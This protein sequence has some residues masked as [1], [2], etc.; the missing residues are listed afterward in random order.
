MNSHFVDFES[1]Q[2]SL[3][4]TNMTL[5]VGYLKE[6]YKDLAERGDKKKGISKITFYDYIK[7]PILIADK[8]FNAL[9]IDNDSYLNSK[10]F[11]E[12][13]QD[14]YMGDFEITL[15]IIFAILDFDKDSKIERDDVR[16]ILSHLPLKT[17]STTLH[18]KYQL[19]SLNEIEDILKCMFEPDEDTLTLD[20][21]KLIIENN[22]S[23]VYLQL[24]CFLYMKKP[25]NSQ[26]I[27][28]LGKST[29]SVNFCSPLNT[30]SSPNLI[31]G[32]KSS[33]KKLLTPNRK[34]TFSP[35]E[36]FIKAS[37]TQS[38]FSL[39][40]SIKSKKSFVD[41]NTPQMSGMKGMVRL[42]N[43]IIPQSKAITNNNNKI[44]NV[45][46][47]A[48]K[49]YVS[50][51]DF[52][53]QHKKPDISN[54]KL[55]NKIIHLGKLDFDI[56]SDS[57]SDVEEDE[58]DNDSQQKAEQD[59]I[60]EISYE[61]W[62][63]KINESNKIIKYFLVIICKDIYYYKNN[64]K[65]ELLGMH[66]LSGCYVKENG[67]KVINQ[68]KYYC[69]Q[70]IFPSKQR[71]YYT[72]TLE[73]A[74]TFVNKIKQQLNYLNF[75]EYYEMIDDLGEG[76]FGQVKLGIHKTTK[77]RVAI[78][79]I[80]RQQMDESDNELVRSEIDIMKLCHHP[81]IVRLLDHFENAEYIFI[82][83]EYIQGGC[84]ESYLVNNKFALSEKRIAKLVYQICQGIQYL[85]QYGIVH[86]DLKP[87]NIMMTSNDH[88]GNIKIMDF[89]L[90]KIIGP[91]ERVVDGFGTLGYVAPEVL[92]RTPYNKQIDVWSIG[93]IVYYML[94][95]N[96]PFDDEN[97]CEEAIAKMIVYIETQ[98]PKDKWSNKSQEAVDF[99]N[100]CLNK[101]METRITISELLKHKW[102]EKFKIVDVNNE[103]K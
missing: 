41:E 65:K 29:K 102:F 100:K 96:L 37:K 88:N 6:I 61:N 90:S 74:Q 46:K 80:N 59:K 2:N 101:N 25:F 78:K 7:L 53:L 68:R 67:N 64:D 24:L 30:K 38:E 49:V 85:H 40:K 18:Y 5:F 47:E 27:H 28:P 51:S 99:I 44:E 52:L 15:E 45:I 22:K 35:A 23:D 79:I 10:E 86:R 14:L 16:L 98:F 66:N 11:V 82:V 32:N 43:E 87:Q 69:F 91:K 72:K 42:N 20:E 19:E 1:L 54:F 103:C 77:E 8:L 95:G 12:G 3:G 58:E 4:I 48:N 34:S 97:D 50:P 60:E 76:K 17:D 31:N 83:M 73:E 21:F 92:V 89:G 26:N 39:S 93:I 55:D 81:N 62:V 71:N 33:S 94:S 63:Y 57:N 84:L 56:S 75:F 36:A 9:D 13:L 70:I